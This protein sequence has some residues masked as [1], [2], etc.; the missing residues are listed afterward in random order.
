M[1]VI[2]KK[3]MRPFPYFDILKPTAKITKTYSYIVVENG[4]FQIEIKLS[5]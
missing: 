5:L 2:N 4:V 1:H 3:N